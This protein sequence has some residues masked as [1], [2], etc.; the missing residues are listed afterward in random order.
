[1]AEFHLTNKAV[2]DLKEIWVYTF[3]EWDEEQADEYYH[4]LLEGCQDAA[5]NP[6]L[7]KNYESIINGL[8]GLNV[9]KHIIFYRVFEPQKVEIIRIL[10][11]KMD[12]KQKM[13]K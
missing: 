10:H 5:D 11:E 2:Q 13:T 12:L 7:G 8:F 3:K 4:I 9:I 1:M 6:L